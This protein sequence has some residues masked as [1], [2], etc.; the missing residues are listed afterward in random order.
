VTGPAWQQA[1][2]AF[3]AAA[4]AAETASSTPAAVVTTDPVVRAALADPDLPASIVRSIHM[5]TAR[6]GGE[7]RI[8]LNPGFLGEMT[9][10]VQVDGASVI[11][12]LHA[13]NSDVREWIRTNEG[14]L[15]QALAEQGFNLERLVVVE[16]EPAESTGGQSRREQEDAEQRPRRNP[17]PAAQGS[18]EALI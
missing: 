7:A 5:Q 14:M 8:S 9:V 12:S 11:A 2:A 3:H 1:I 15:R 4:A 16:D 17:R 13:S 6:G 10:G 18:F